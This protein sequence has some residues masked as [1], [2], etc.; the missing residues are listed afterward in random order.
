MSTPDILLQQQ[1][2]AVKTLAIVANR[3]KKWV[4]D[5]E[6]KEWLTPEEFEGKFIQPPYI[7]KINY[8]FKVLNPVDG[9]IAADTQIQQIMQKRKDLQIR[10]VHYYQSKIK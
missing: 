6:M 7:D 4:F 1:V 9:L 2:V 3:E 5:S 10:V 8:R